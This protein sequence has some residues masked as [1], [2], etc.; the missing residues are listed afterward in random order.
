M[1]ENRTFPLIFSS[2]TIFI[3]SYWA[4]FKD[5]MPCLTCTDPWSQDDYDDGFCRWLRF[6]SWALDAW[7]S[8]N[9]I[10][11][12]SR[13]CNSKCVLLRMKQGTLMK[14]L[15]AS[16]F[17]ELRSILSFPLIPASRLS[18]CSRSAL[19]YIKWVHCFGLPLTGINIHVAM[20]CR[21]SVTG[22][23]WCQPLEWAQRVVQQTERKTKFAKSLLI[24]IFIK[25]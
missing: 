15:Q 14:E 6:T 20:Q 9:L 24:S 10:R 11:C 16:Y 25:S 8:Y 13:D 23:K 17:I 4:R 21:A 7:G 19:K 2:L 3:L 18:C 1:S 12:V 22:R 5:F